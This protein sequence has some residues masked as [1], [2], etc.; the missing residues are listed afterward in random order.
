MHFIQPFLHFDGT[1]DVL[2]L[3]CWDIQVRSDQISQNPGRLDI[4]NHLA[5]FTRQVGSQIHGLL[6]KVL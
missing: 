5:H 3:H 1:E 4:R 6:K 2:F